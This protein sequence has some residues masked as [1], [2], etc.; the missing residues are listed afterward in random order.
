[1][2]GSHCRS[3][4]EPA[5]VSSGLLVTAPLEDVRHFRL[6]LLLL[7]LLRRLLVLVLLRMLQGGRTWLRGRVGAAPGSVASRRPRGHLH[8]RGRALTGLVLL[9]L[10]APRQRLCQRLQPILQHHTAADVS[11]ELH[12]IAPEAAPE[13]A[14][15]TE[16]GSCPLTQAT[17]QP[18]L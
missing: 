7:L 1:M 5:A 17:L 11:N 18:H 9:P 12:L 3:C 15:T 8:A 2:S 13:R 10:G 6:L 16:S 14:E 4:A